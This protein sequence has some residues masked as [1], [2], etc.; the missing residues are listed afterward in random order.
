M[1]I[2]S[3]EFVTGGFMPRIYTQQGENVS[4]PLILEDVPEVAK[5]LVLVCLDPDAPDPEHPQRT[6][7]HWIAYNLPIQVK[8][9]PKAVKISS[10]SPISAEGYNDQ[11]KI[12][13]VG[14]RPPI[15]AHR[16]FFKLYALDTTLKFNEPPKIKEFLDAIDGHVISS[17]ETMGLYKLQ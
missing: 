12:G 8:E 16:Y 7:T 13:Y 5:S 17:A 15:G 4:P 6:F 11:N 9:L 1:K 10:L 2:T 3:P 14:P